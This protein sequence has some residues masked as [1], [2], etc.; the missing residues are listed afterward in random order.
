MRSMPLNLGP[1]RTLV[2]DQA[3]LAKGRSVHSAFVVHADFVAAREDDTRVYEV[4][5]CE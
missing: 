4:L 2:E 3:I 1:G 5:H